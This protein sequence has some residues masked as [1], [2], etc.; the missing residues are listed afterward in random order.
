MKPSNAFKPSKR[1]EPTSCLLPAGL[2]D[3][4]AAGVRR[5]SLATSLYRAAMIGLL[6]AIV[7]VKDSG[8]SGFLDRCVTT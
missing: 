5:I 2:P 1:P 4:S 3:L 7:E 6:D 8:Q